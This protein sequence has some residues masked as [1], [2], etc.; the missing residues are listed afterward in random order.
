MKAKIVL[1]KREE[2]DEKKG[3]RMRKVEKREK[4][5]ERKV[6]IKKE[7]KGKDE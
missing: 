6:E 3:L 2:K 7:E 5:E 4:N 1:K